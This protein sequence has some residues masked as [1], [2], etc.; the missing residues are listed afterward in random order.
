MGL[1]FREAVRA[2]ISF[3]KDDVVIPAE[4]AKLVGETRKLVEEYEQ[5]YADGLITKGEKYKQGGG[6]PWAK[7]TDRVGRRHDG[8]DLDP[9]QG[10]GRAVSW[11]STPST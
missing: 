9:S 4:K 5:Q 7:A 10:Q 1:G 2:G 3:G 11:R 6:T 8:R